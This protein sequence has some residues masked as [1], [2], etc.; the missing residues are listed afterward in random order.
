M[1]GTNNVM[2]AGPPEIAAGVAAVV[3]AVRGLSGRTRVLLHGVF[4]RGRAPNPVR[5]R[6][7]AVNQRLRSL[8]DGR[9][10][11]FLDIGA[12]FLG[13]GATVAAEVMP[14]AL[15]LSPKGY[16]I[17]AEAIEPSLR[18]LGGWGPPSG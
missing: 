12:A 8:D 3:E 18:S 10:I 13:P 9:A 4:P 16:Q 6:L 7:R 2:T 14:D 11:R 17:W 15:H 5:D 1:I